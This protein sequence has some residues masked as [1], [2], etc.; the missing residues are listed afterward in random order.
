[1]DAG[2]VQTLLNL[3]IIA[4]VPNYG[5]LRRD[6][7]GGLSL[8]KNDVLAPV[9]RYL[10]NDGRVQMVCDITQVIDI[11]MDIIR[12]LIG[13]DGAELKSDV[14]SLHY[15]KSLIRELNYCESGINN[16]K[17]TYADDV[18][19]CSQL[20]LLVEKIDNF[21]DTLSPPSDVILTM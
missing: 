16:L 14:D 11:A 15:C 7:D 17:N 2:V 1:M 20:C 3:K 12:Q 21:I 5:R 8:E 18:K 9:R 4:K 19:I 13:N 6:N 10:F